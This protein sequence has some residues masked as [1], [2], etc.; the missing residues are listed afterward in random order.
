MIVKGQM[1]C[2][3]GTR[4]SAER[5]NDFATPGCLHSMSKRQVLCGF[6]VP[7]FGVG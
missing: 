3:R 7:S 2:V 5:V 1:K 4:P 6:G